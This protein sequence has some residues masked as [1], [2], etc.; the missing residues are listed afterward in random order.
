LEVLKIGFEK[1]SETANVFNQAV[2]VR[3]P[4]RCRSLKPVHERVTRLDVD[5]GLLI[6]DG[7]G[8]FLFSS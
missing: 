7:H 4:G 5:A 1:S 3:P 2:L 6:I 8:H